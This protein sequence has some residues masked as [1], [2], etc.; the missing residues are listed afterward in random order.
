VL[1]QSVGILVHYNWALPYYFIRT[2]DVEIVDNI[3]SFFTILMGGFYY[4]FKSQG[5]IKLSLIKSGISGID[6]NNLVKLLAKMY[7]KRVVK[8]RNYDVVHINS[9]DVIGKEF[10]KLPLPRVFVLHGSLDFANGSVCSSLNEIYSTVEAFVV[11]SMHAATR[12]N[13]L[14]GFRPT[15]IIHHGIDVEIFNPTSYPKDLARRI[16]GLPKDK[17]IILWNARMEREKKLETLIKALP[18]VVREYKDILILIKTRTIDPSYETMIQKLVN[19]LNV[20]KYVVF[21]E[22]WS[23]LIKMPLY[24]RAADIYVNTSVTEAFGS[25]TMLEAMACGTPTVANNASSNPEAL[26]DGGLLYNGEPYDLAEKLM[27][28]LS[29]SKLAKALSY[30]AYKRIVNG[31]TLVHTARKYCELYKFI[32]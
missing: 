31:L 18:Y 12:L 9:Y 8:E 24:Y 5:R 7:A 15:T 17:K 20:E 13:E 6:S 10:L 22:R 11:V 3:T 30:K 14:C 27:K 26:G 29:D 23:P 16:L 19:K 28:I 1:F 25:L 21:D 32:S 4:L 2:T